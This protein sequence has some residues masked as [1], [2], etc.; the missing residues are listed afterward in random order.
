MLDAAP[1]H[2]ERGRLA[3]VEGHVPVLDPH[4]PAVD[5]AVVL[6]DVSGGEDA[7][8][9]VSSC[10]EHFTPPASPISSPALLASVTS[11][12]TPAPITTGSQSS[13][14]PLRVTTFSTRPPEPSKCSSSSP[15]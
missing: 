6:A 7:G 2:V 13:S 15:P 3:L 5:R 8:H 10:A 14:S 1:E 11:G 9:R 4:R 12:V